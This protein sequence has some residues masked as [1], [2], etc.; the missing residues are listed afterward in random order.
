MEFKTKP[1]EEPLQAPRRRPRLQR[2]VVYNL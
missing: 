1:K 2:L